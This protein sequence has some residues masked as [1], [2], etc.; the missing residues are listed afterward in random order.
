MEILRPAIPASVIALV[1]RKESADRASQFGDTVAEELPGGPLLLNSISPGTEGGARGPRRRLVPT[2]MSYFKVLVRGERLPPKPGRADD[3]R[4]PR[5][6]AVA[7]GAGQPAV[8]PLPRVLRPA[9]NPAAPP[10]S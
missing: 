3:F 8:G 6:D 2:Q 1:T 7:T 4:W 10:K 5:P 9:P